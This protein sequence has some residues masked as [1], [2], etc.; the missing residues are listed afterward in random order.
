M[1]ETLKGLY[2]SEDIG[3]DAALLV[4]VALNGVEASLPI[5]I[6]GAETWWKMVVMLARPG[7]Q[8][9]SEHIRRAERGQRAIVFRPEVLTNP[10][11][12][13]S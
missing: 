13:T 9:I 5:Y 3:R 11:V 4:S 6:E 12:V 10:W 1:S 7:S 8:A 2:E